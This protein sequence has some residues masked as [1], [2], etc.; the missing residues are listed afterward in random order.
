MHDSIL[1]MF[2]FHYTNL[3]NLFQAQHVINYNFPMFESDYIHRAGRVGRVGSM[4]KGFVLSFVSQKWEVDLLWKL[5]VS[6]LFEMSCFKG[7]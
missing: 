2:I 3:L 7:M 6:Y 4:N 1:V 5:E